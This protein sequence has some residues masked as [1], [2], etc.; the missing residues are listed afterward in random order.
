MA[1]EASRQVL[2]G[3]NDRQREAVSAVDGPV[4]VV[5]GAGSGKTRVLTRRVVYLLEHGVAPNEILAI[6]FT[7]KAAREMAERVHELVSIEASQALWIS[8]FHAACSRILRVHPELGRLRSGFTIY[9]ADDARRLLERTIRSLEL[10]TKR[11]PPRAVMA[12]IS[13]AKADLIGPREMALDAVGAYDRLVA[14]LYQ[15]YEDA[16]IANNAVDFDNLVNLVVT[17]LREHPGVREYYQRRFRYLLVDEYQDTN[18]A[19]NELISILAEP[20]KN[21]FVVGDSDQSI[22]GFR[23]ADLGN[24]IGFSERLP[25][26]RTIA[27]EQNYRSTNAILELANTLITHNALRHDKTLWSE[28]GQGVLPLYFVAQDDRQE[29]EFVVSQLVTLLSSGSSLRDIAVIYRTNAQSRVLEEELSKG[30]IPYRVVGGVRFYDR[31]EIRDILAYLRILV[32]PDDDVALLRVINTPHR[33]IGA[34]TQEQLAAAARTRNVSMLHALELFSTDELGLSSRAAKALSHFMELLAYLRQRVQEGAPAPLVLDEVIERTEY[35]DLINEED[36][37]TAE[38]RLEN[39]AELRRVAG[40]A[41]SLEAFLEQTALFS[42]IDADLDQSSMTL[43]TVHMAKGLEFPIVFVVGLEEGIFPHMRSLTSPSQ[44]EEER[45]LL[46][47]AVTRAKQRLMISSARRRSFQGSVIY[48]PESRFITELPDGVYRRL[49]SL[50]YSPIPVPEHQQPPRP[51]QPAPYRVGDRVFHARYGEGEVRAIRERSVD[52]E[53]VV[54]F[55]AAGERVFFG[56]MAKLK[57]V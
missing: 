3:L 2:E 14:T 4:L 26:T 39:L 53:V 23:G 28:L 44:I 16:L 45:R 41:D 51:G 46:Y 37:L 29:A 42:A 27:L 43:M 56:S 47:V 7:N 5:A 19:Q 31:R 35:V 54:Y 36:P 24:I 17:G 12:K 32:N 50:E 9:D 30:G 21:I 25:T 22:Y 34:G 57:L 49:E 15:A 6:T 18:R 52:R 10:D 33:G 8:T 11:F 13:S 38:G 55:D 48:N 20:E 1:A 40:E